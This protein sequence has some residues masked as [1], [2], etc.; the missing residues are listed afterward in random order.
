VNVDY[1]SGETHPSN[2]AHLFMQNS[3]ID[4]KDVDALINQWR[5]KKDECA[6]R[7]ISL[8][9]TAYYGRMAEAERDIAVM[10]VKDLEALH[11]KAK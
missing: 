4:G 8:K 6:S 9:A 7:A 5:E 10:I 3:S 1:H 2:N 11:L